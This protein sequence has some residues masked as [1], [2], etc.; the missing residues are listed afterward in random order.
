MEII[1]PDTIALLGPLFTD[2]GRPAKLAERALPTI[3]RPG[4]LADSLRRIAARRDGGGY[5]VMAAVQL[6]GYEAVGGQQAWGLFNPRRSRE[7]SEWQF[8]QFARADVLASIRSWLGRFAERFPESL[9]PDR[10]R[11]LLVPADPANRAS[12]IGSAGLAVFGGVPGL[13]LVRLWPSRGN[14]ARLGPSLARAFGHNLRWLNAPP[15]ERPTLGDLLVGEGLAAALVARAFP[16]VSAPWLVSFSPPPDWEEALAQIAQLSGAARFD[17]VPANIYGSE[18]PMGLERPIRPAPLDTEELAYARAVVDEALDATEP[19]TIAAH[20]YGDELVA[21][22]GHP[23]VGLPSDAGFEVGYRRV[24]VALER[25]GGDLAALLVL[26]T[27][28]ILRLS[29]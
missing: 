19:R 9:L 10:L 8:E 28:E 5:E 16:E 20:L 24:E 23:S 1:V 4:E 22:Q 13:I 25:T 18:V 29:G 27:A 15:V 6:D 26:P 11:C 12:L 17:E 3:H 14:L 2:R 21:A 7:A